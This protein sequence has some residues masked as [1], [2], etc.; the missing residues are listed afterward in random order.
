MWSSSAPQDWQSRQRHGE[1]ARDCDASMLQCAP[2]TD[3]ASRFCQATLSVAS[4]DLR[5]TSCECHATTYRDFVPKTTTTNIQ[6]HC[7][8]LHHISHCDKCQLVTTK[9]LSFNFTPVNSRSKCRMLTDT[10]TCA[11][12]RIKLNNIQFQYYMALTSEAPG[13]G[14]V[15]NL[16]KVVK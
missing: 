15:N 2:Q 1:T 11:L 6:S 14:Y 16:A 4:G 8:L 3:A 5:A 9:I 12:I 10:L 13:K 7:G